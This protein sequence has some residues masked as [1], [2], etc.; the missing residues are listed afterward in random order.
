M[1]NI[2]PLIVLERKAIIHMGLPKKITAVALSVLSVIA[3]N[4]AVAHAAPQTT[5]G[6]TRNIVYA[7]AP[8]GSSASVLPENAFYTPWAGQIAYAVNTQSADV[9]G[10][11]VPYDALW[12]TGIMSYDQSVADGVRSVESLMRRDLKR[13]P[14]T[15]VHL[16]GYSEGA[17]VV[18][19]AFQNVVR[20]HVPGV[21]PEQV[22]SV[23]RVSAPSRQS[24]EGVHQWGSAS[25]G[26]GFAKPL[27]FG[28]YSSRVEELCNK[29]DAVCD[30]ARFAQE[31]RTPTQAGAT[32]K[33][34]PVPAGDKRKISSAVKSITSVDELVDTVGQLPLFAAGWAVHGQYFPD[35]FAEVLRFMSTRYAR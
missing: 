27:H 3:M 26:R 5:Q 31:W 16:T 17:D 23:V 9:K 30:T 20:G 34:L 25:G 12:P 19:Y 4:H 28:A 8:S 1:M 21:K 7:V 14:Q 10:V 18:G 32:I 6:C 11:V 24:G 22:G 13:C 29:G 33:L 15:R 35:G 2:Y